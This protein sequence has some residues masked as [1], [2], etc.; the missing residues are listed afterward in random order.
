[1]FEPQATNATWHWN[2]HRYF[3]EPLWTHGLGPL[4]GNPSLFPAGS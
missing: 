4:T 3:G 2:R 1:M